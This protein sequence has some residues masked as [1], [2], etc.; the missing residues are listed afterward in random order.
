M[1]SVENHIWFNKQSK[2]NQAIMNKMFQELKKCYDECQIVYVDNLEL[3][4]E[5]KAMNFNIDKKREYNRSLKKQEDRKLIE[6]W[7]K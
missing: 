4:F 7:G 2:I 3:P 5:V 6:E 1:L